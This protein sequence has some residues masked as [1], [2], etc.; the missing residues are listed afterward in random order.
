MR[1]KK[2]VLYSLVKFLLALILTAFP[3]LFLHAVPE[4]GEPRIRNF[5]PHEYGGHI[6]IWSI[7]QDPRGVIYFGTMAEILEF[8]GKTWKK[9][10]LPNHAAVRSMIMDEQGTIYIGGYE[11]FG[12]LGC[13]QSGETKYHSLLEYVPS[14]HRDFKD[15][16]NVWVNS[17]GV[18]FCTEKKVFC[19]Q[20]HQLLIYP[21]TYGSMC[22]NIND[23]LLLFS[24]SEITHLQAGKETALPNT[25]FLQYCGYVSIVPYNQ[26]DILIITEKKGCY[27]YP[28]SSLNSRHSPP[29]ARKFETE[30]DGYIF[31][32]NFYK[33]VRLKNMHYALM[34]QKGG[35][36]LMDLS[37]RLERIISE[38]QGLLNNNVFALF[39]DRQNNL[40]CGMQGGIAY[41]EISSP[42]SRFSKLSGIDSTVLSVTRHQGRIYAGTYNSGPKPL[43]NDRFGNQEISPYFCE[44]QNFSGKF[45]W[46]F[47]SVGSTLLV[48]ADAIYRIL[49]NTASIIGNTPIA[50]CLHHSKKFPDLIFAGITEVSNGGLGIMKIEG[51][52][53]FTFQGILPGISE[54]IRNITEDSQGDIWL[55][56]YLSGIIHVHFRGKTV[57]DITV[58]C[59]NAADNPVFSGLCHILLFENQIV[60]SSSQGVFQAVPTSFKKKYRFIP[61]TDM[62]LPTPSGDKNSEAAMKLIS[63]KPDQLLFLH[64]ELGFI[65]LEKGGMRPVDFRPFKGIS[66]IQ[67]RIFVEPDGKIWI[68]CDDGLYRFDPA[69]IKNYAESYHVL[70][71][72]VQT[73]SGQIIFH[74]N[75]FV[76]ESPKE[77]SSRQISQPQSADSMI[78]LPFA[79]NSLTFL[80]SSLYF[81]QLEKN[82]YQ[83]QLKGYDSDWSAWQQDTKKEYNYIPEGSYCFQVQARN[84]YDHPSQ[85]A[86]FY[87][88]I[89]APWYRTIYAYAAFLCV[90]SYLIFF[91]IRLNTRRLVNAKRKLETMVNQ[92]TKEIISQKEKIEGINQQLYETNRQLIQTKNA[93][94]GEM[95]LAKKIQTLL[96]P[97]HPEI[98][99]YEIAVY[100]QPADEV[101]GDY[102]DVISIDNNDCRG[103]ACP[104]PH[105]SGQSLKTNSENPPNLLPGQPQEFAPTGSSQ[106]STLYH[107]PSNS[108]TSHWISIGD[109]S[110]HGVPAGLIMM[111]VQTAIRSI[112]QKNSGLT[113]LDILE[114]AN[115]V[116][117]DNIKRMGEDKY[118]TIVLMAVQEDGRI[119]YSGLHQ[120][121]LIYRQQEKRVEIV[122]TKGMWIGM[123]E[124]IEN[125]ITVDELILQPGDSLLLYTDGLTEAKNQSFEMYDTEKLIDIFSRQDNLTMEDIKNNIL[126]SLNGYTQADDIT[127][128]LLK[129]SN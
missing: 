13:D 80:Y 108:L 104:H 115:A 93:L 6:Q 77:N 92:R 78:S 9:H 38:K 117:Y 128:L 111:M 107:L 102:Y 59:Y 33:A 25:K 46:D 26:D 88:S 50:Y 20:K 7:I 105:Y 112:L 14:E 35:I 87:F 54:V 91:G 121:M 15:I 82:Q 94:W 71:R 64:H 83:Y 110:G 74:G 53:Q 127:L 2:C 95:Q 24:G 70:I 8:D 55:S 11:E 99:G 89:K 124:S 41:I 106:K 18:F 29:M 62:M 118:M 1:I 44:M 86:R 96:L 61:K 125:M 79:E 52:Q 98:P 123:T 21:V 58:T 31:E 27:L 17:E 60:V 73:K 109:V 30:A 57:N 4:I 16:W 122:E 69:I 37:G 100:M 3:A 119:L 103:G 84:I 12:Y 66:L 51:N 43:I 90:L 126:N 72:Q 45:A 32:M 22:F 28:L 116:I 23:H 39:Q 76:P 114:R 75:S 129:R 40:W 68:P 34:T 85:I 101:G 63:Y 42:L 120:D 113:P 5:T 19:W 47:L 48:A 65:S 81:E 67:D 10:L 56:T 97:T 49:G 36:A